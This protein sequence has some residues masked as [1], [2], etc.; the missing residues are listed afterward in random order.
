MPDPNPD[1]D[2]VIG[3]SDGHFTTGEIIWMLAFVLFALCFFI[4]AEQIAKLFRKMK[5]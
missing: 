1:L 3:N 5:P 2:D 4:P